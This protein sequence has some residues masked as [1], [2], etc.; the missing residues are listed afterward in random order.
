[1]EIQANRSLVIIGA[2]SMGIA[3]ILGALGAQ[4]L[5]SVLSADSLDSFKTGVRYQAWHSLAILMLGLAGQ[6][7]LN[8]NQIKLLARLFIAGIFMFCL[9]I[10]LLTCKSILGIESWIS[11]IGP[12]T[13]LGGLGL[14]VA[15]FSLGAMVLIKKKS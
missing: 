2:F 13:P 3:V 14:I 8:K 5:E 10:Y 7:I 4:A 6:M 11:V 9:S 1:M 15:W 12:I